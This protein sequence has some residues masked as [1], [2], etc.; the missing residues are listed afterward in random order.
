MI[1]LVYFNTY[2]DYSIL[3][4]SPIFPHKIILEV[5]S[6]LGAL[7]IIPLQRVRG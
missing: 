2:I 7:K 4:F 3:T 5:R 6:K 1:I